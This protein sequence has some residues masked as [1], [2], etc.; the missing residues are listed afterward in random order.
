[1]AKDVGAS[2]WQLGALKTVVIVVLDLAVAEE[3]AVLVLKDK[4]SHSD[5][6]N[7]L[8]RNVGLGKKRKLLH[9][10]FVGRIFETLLNPR[11]HS[12]PSQVDNVSADAKSRFH[13]LLSEVNIF[14]VNRGGLRYSQGLKILD[15][16]H[17]TENITSVGFLKFATKSHKFI[18]S[19]IF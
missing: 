7:A 1:M 15:C 18:E 16:R 10:L 3:G 6:P 14:P 2:V 5:L 12:L 17:C 19:E 11:R 13:S 8:E 9:W 4:A